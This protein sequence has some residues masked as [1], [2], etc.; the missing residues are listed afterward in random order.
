[1]HERIENDYDDL[2]L[3][4]PDAVSEFI[5]SAKVY[6]AYVETLIPSPEP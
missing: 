6:V 2:L 3:S 1:M 4:G 5:E